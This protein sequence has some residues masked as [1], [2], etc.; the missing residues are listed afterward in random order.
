MVYVNQST[1]YKDLY[2]SL[3]KLYHEI[4]LYSCNYEKAKLL[5]IKKIDFSSIHYYFTECLLSLCFP[6]V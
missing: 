5:P 3:Y 1:K 6:S 2:G 4:E